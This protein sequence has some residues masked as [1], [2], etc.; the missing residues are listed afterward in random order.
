MTLDRL[1][2]IDLAID[3]RL[4]S[5]EDRMGGQADP[6]LHAAQFQIFLIVKEVAPG[7]R[8][9]FF[10]FGVPFFDSRKE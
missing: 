9:D 5:F 1:A 6:S 8:G 4:A 7:A 10:W 2:R 3:V